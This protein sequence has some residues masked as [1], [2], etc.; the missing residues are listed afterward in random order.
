MKEF[1]INKNE[2]GQRFDKYLKKLLKEAPDSFLY[3]M[4]RKKNITL[5]GKKAEGRELLQEQDHVKLF[6][7]DETFEKFHGAGTQKNSATGQEYPVCKLE[8][9]YEDADSLIINKPAGMLSQKAK[10]ADVSAN[11]YIIGYLLQ[12]GAITPESLA[13]FRPSICNRLDRNTSG[14]LIAGKSLA[15]LQYWSSALKERTIE[16]YYLALVK[17]KVEKDSHLKG[18]LTKDRAGNQVR[19]LENMSNNAEQSYIET[20]FE[21]VQ[22]WKD[23][24]LLK[25]H[26]ITGR[27]HQIRAHLASIGHPMIGDMKYGDMQTNQKWKKDAG[28][29]RQMLH[30]YE[31]ITEDGRTYRAEIPADMQHA[32]DVLNR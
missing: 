29:K 16:K 30:A 19:I 1:V 31:L 28:V 14:L 24:S 15:G 3:K 20:S 4:L 27:T 11:E 32:I 10:P 7:S 17:G 9:V 5:N 18:Y 2:A 13:T 23:V 22:A 21:V 8:I 12:R 6:L 26:L 25:V